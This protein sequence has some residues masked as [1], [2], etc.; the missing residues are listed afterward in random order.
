MDPSDAAQRA[1]AR[2][3]VQT[4]YR[5]LTVGCG[6]TACT[7]AH[8]RASASAADA[9]IQSVYL[10]THAPVPL[11]VPLYSSS[12][13]DGEAL[14]ALDKQSERPETD[15]DDNDNNS[16]E[17]TRTDVTEPSVLSALSSTPRR[18]L[19][20]AVELDLTL[21]ASTT[22]TASDDDEDDRECRTSGDARQFLQARKLS[23]PKQKLL[24]A[25]T[26]S[27]PSSRRIELERRRG[28]E[29]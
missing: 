9:A 4:Y 8:C 24:D 1:Y 10:A 23:L 18:R 20:D 19:S 28:T 7:N 15:D 17:R 27:F 22:T 29:R 5:M 6:A 25:I 12:S 26:K 11:C 16:D 14:E 2:A 21:G 13:S 3:L